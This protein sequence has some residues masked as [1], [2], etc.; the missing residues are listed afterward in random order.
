MSKSAI[1]R[2]RWTGSI[3]RP[4]S[5][6]I[7]P[8]LSASRSALPSDPIPFAPR[9]RR[10]LRGRFHLPFRPCRGAGNNGAAHRTERTRDALRLRFP[11]P[12]PP[13]PPPQKGGGRLSGGGGVENP[14][15]QTVWGG[16]GACSPSRPPRSMFD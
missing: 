6:V 8:S 10:R 3:R 1:R 4:I 7:R 15:F 12:R 13:P 14:P 5:P 2:P 9:P 11:P 16:G